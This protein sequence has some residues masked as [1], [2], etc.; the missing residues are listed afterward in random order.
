M[1]RII[2]L[3][4]GRTAGA[5]FLFLL[6]TFTS[7]LPCSA[8]SF[9]EAWYRRRGKASMR[10]NDFRAAA[11]AFEKVVEE[12][13]RDPEALLSLAQAY[14][15]EG[16]RDK[17][18][19]FY[20]LYLE[21]NPR[22]ARI[23]FQQATIL[24][25]QEFIYRRPDA[26]KYYAMGLRAKDDPVERFRSAKML[27]EKRETSAEAARQFELVLKEKPRNAEAHYGA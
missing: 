20:D 12:N 4:A 1:G 23:A 24:S 19:D 2:P 27:G 10:I 7:V 6:L 11:E 21:L 14:E 8:S 16:F 15:A 18:V 26:L 3:T 13:P 5:G 22:D 9:S 17:A 25:W